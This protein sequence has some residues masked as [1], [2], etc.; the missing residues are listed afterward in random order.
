MY[1]CLLTAVTEPF[2]EPTVFMEQS[3]PPTGWMRQY[4]LQPVPQLPYN[5]QTFVPVPL[6]VRQHILPDSR[7]VISHHQ[8][9]IVQP[10]NTRTFM[11]GP[12]RPHI[13]GVQPPTRQAYFPVPRYHPCFPPQV[14]RP[15]GPWH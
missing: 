3:H 8:M 12:H 1:F 4:H 13:F 6:P 5:P 11:M 10:S 2:I 15:F 14:F 7:F 9:G